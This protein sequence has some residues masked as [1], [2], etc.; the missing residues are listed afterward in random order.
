[1]HRL[2]PHTSNFAIQSTLKSEATALSPKPGEARSPSGPGAS[3]GRILHG[4]R[5]HRGDRGLRTG[6][7]VRGG[8]NRRVRR[9]PLGLLAV[10]AL[11]LSAGPLHAVDL[12]V[13]RDLLG[14]AALLGTSATAFVWTEYWS[15]TASTGQALHPGQPRQLNQAVDNAA[16]YAVF[17]AMA[18][19]LVGVAGDGITAASLNTSLRYASAIFTAAAL[20][21]LFKATLPRPRPYVAF[22]ASPDGSARGATDDPIDPDA[23]RSFPSGHATLAWTAFARSIWTRWEHPESVPAR[24]SMWGTGALAVT[25]SV[26]RVVAGAHYPGDVIA[27]AL[28]GLAVGGLT[29]L[30]S[31]PGAG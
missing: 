11:I 26:L 23:F 24:L 20:K 1:M 3:G 19:P 12:P 15:S 4:R 7:G 27:G 17:G 14:E 5:I 9:A 31:L 8:S 30:I 21:D 22:A 16:L 2:K 10:A 28:L 6:R 18:L 25:V 13:P 29:P